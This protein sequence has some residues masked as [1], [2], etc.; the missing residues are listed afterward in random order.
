MRWVGIGSVPFRL[1]PLDFV[2][3]GWVIIVVLWL[4]LILVVVMRPTLVAA[5]DDFVDDCRGYN[6][7][8]VF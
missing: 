4:W 7:H 8:S 3:F 6:F 5:G 2:S 1:V